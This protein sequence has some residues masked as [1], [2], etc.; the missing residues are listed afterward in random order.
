M[1]MVMKVMMMLLLMMMMM[2]MMVMMVMVMM[3]VTSLKLWLQVLFSGVSLEET[4]LAMEKLV[5]LGL[6]KAIG[7]SNFNSKQV[8]AMTVMLVMLMV[9]VV[10]VELVGVT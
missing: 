7:L 2:M 1:M 8:T 4:W 5:H 10:M 6:V 3:A 9:M